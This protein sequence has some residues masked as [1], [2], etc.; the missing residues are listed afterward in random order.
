MDS[1]ITILN[2]DKKRKIKPKIMLRKLTNCTTK[3]FRL[4]CDVLNSDF[5][6]MLVKN[7]SKDHS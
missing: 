7:E 3:L 4:T 2:N 1:F 5:K 6:A